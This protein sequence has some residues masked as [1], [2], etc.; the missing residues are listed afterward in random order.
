MFCPAVSLPKP[1]LFT[2]A[3]SVVKSDDVLNQAAT[4]NCESFNAE[5]LATSKKLEPVTVKLGAYVSP[6]EK[7]KYSTC[8]AVLNEV[9][10]NASDTC[11]AVKSSFQTRTSSTFPIKKLA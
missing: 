9:P 3:A 10:A 6:P 7:S 11:W 5:V 4:L 2:I 8:S 1:P